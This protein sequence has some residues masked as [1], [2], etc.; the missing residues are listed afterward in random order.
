MKENKYLFIYFTLFLYLFFSNESFAFADCNSNKIISPYKSNNI[1]SI[2]IDILNKKKWYKNLYNVVFDLDNIFIKQKYKKRFKAK[3][4]INYKFNKSCQLKASV[5]LH[6]DTPE[7][8]ANSFPSLSVKIINGNINNFTDFILF[9]PETRKGDNEIFNSTLAKNLGFISPD[10]FYINTSLNGANFKY[11]LQERAA[12]ELIENFGRREGPLLEGDERHVYDEKSNETL[13]QRTHKSL[14][15]MTNSNWALRSDINLETSLNILENMNHVYQEF[16]MKLNNGSTRYFMNFDLIN[17]LNQ[18]SLEH[19]Y[20]YHAFLYSIKG[21][22]GLAYHNRKYYYD[23]LNNFLYPIFYDTDS[24]IFSSNRSKDYLLDEK[25]VLEK[26]IVDA[27][28]ILLARLNEISLDNFKKELEIRGLFV[29]KK[30]IEKNFLKIKENID[31]ISRLNIKLDETHKKKLFF[32]SIKNF[33]HI[34]IGFFSNK[35]NILKYCDLHLV[36]CNDK[37]LSAK[38]IKRLIEQRLVINDIDIVF[39]ASNRG[40]YENSNINK[41]NNLK[42]ELPSIKFENFSLYYKDALVEK[43]L[44][45][46]TLK[47]IA[48]N[49]D[50]IVAIFG[51]NVE[52]W[53]IEYNGF[54]SDQ[55]FS[56]PYNLTGCLN[57]FTKS[58]AIKKIIVFD[59][60]C[61]DAINFINTNGY[62]KQIGIYKA[63]SDGIDSDFSNINFEEI[64]VFNAKND[65]VDFSYGKYLIKKIKLNQCRDKGISVGEA[66]ILDI[67]N[68]NVSNS[69][70]GVASKDSSLVN[71]NLTNFYEVKKCVAIYNKKFE[72]NSSTLYMT[73]NTECENKV[74][75][76]D[77]SLLKIN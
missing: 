8:Y 68:L 31:I 74:D 67:K 61:E 56:Y 33:N 62:V 64:E 24:T 42:K 14:V 16:L 18:K 43:N 76:E 38:Q 77:G 15:R 45:D 7:H 19:L 44:K 2:S 21:T 69:S 73:K 52:E 57:F 10:T 48:K 34:N 4:T 27:S 5:R 40:N 63:Y 29:N 13:S 6:G 70:I 65:C 39:V 28:V 55:L 20:T 37:E 72:F 50:S 60:K 46:K 53:E 12:K 59:A 71:L 41:L 36:F 23:Y 54:K 26:K 3:L 25:L 35:K 51:E 47:I 17:N 49:V 11:L 32:N 75:I 22:H 30:K 66:S 1:K 58:I 9:R